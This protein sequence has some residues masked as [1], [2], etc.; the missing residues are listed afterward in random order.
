MDKQ[1]LLDLLIKY[2]KNE[3]T[4]EEI[5]ILKKWFEGFPEVREESDLFGGEAEDDVRDRVWSSMSDNFEESP[6]PRRLDRWWFKA[7]AALAVFLLIGIYW[8]RYSGEAP[9]GDTRLI[10][11]SYDQSSR[12]YL[13]D[14]SMLL[15]EPN[16]TVRYSSDFLNDRT[17]YLQ[18]ACLFHVKKML[19][20][21][22]RV[23]SKE[24]ITTV[25]GTIFSVKAYPEDDEV[26]THLLEGSVRVAHQQK[27]DSMHLAPN[28]IAVLSTQ[29]GRFTKIEGAAGTAAN[30]K[31]GVSGSELLFDAISYEEIFAKLEARFGV[32]IY[33]DRSNLKECY[34]SARFRTETLEEILAILAS[35]NHF[36]YHITGGIVY[37]EDFEC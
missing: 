29:S 2:E 8:A 15:L 16:S 18:G 35:I 12:L 23:V 22:F 7:A 36:K 31:P 6:A 13:P 27:T 34:F 5:A 1:E 32:M 28:E 33:V 9:G 21:P 26:T 19:E 30:R 10:T 17:V 20:A 25:T 3:C 24:Q 4:E 14:S 11:F 37:I